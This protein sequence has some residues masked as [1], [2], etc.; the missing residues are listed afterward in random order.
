MPT[1]K[2]VIPVI[3]IGARFFCGEIFPII[4]APINAPKPSDEANIPI[5][6]SDNNNFS[7]PN[8][9]IRETKGNP[10][11]LKIKVTSKTNLKLNELYA[12][13]PVFNIS[14]NNPCAQ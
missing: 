12:L 14:F 7:L 11:I 1:K 4:R 6:I 13:L 3:N 2:P 9:G 8:T 5:L 10:K